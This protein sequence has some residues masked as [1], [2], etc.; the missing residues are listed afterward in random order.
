MLVGN[1][2]VY[3]KVATHT[4]GTIF[5]WS[6]VT[7]QTFAFGNNTEKHS[8]VQSNRRLDFDRKF[9]CDPSRFINQ[10]FS[11][12]FFIVKIQTDTLNDRKNR[13]LVDAFKLNPLECEQ[14]EEEADCLRISWGR[15]YT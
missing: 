10:L 8:N 13:E 9:G 15:D 14:L 12:I 7:G 1:V 2:G 4:S 5:D 11:T 3:E 6:R